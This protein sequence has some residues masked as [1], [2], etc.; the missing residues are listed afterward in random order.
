MGLCQLVNTDKDSGIIGDMTDIKRRQEIYGRH[1][2]AMPKI[3]SFITLLA[4][5][6]EDTNVIFL[7]WAATIYLGIS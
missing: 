4:R 5:Q 7:M 3:E 6:F 1:F 2:I